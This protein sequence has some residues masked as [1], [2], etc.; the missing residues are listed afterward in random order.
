MNSLKMLLLTG[1][2]LLLVLPASLARTRNSSNPDYDVVRDFSLASNPNGTWSYGWA[3]STKSPFNLYTWSANNCDAGM[4]Y[5]GYYLGTPC[6]AL[7]TVGHN[8]TDQTLCYTTW[9]LPPNYLG[10][11]D[12]WIMQGDKY[13]DQL[14][15]VRWTAPSS[16]TFL[17]QGAV[18]GLDYGGT[19]LHVVVNSSMILFYTQVTYHTPVYFRHSLRLNAGDTV[20]FAVGW[21]ANQTI[22]GDATGI[23]FNL[24]LEDAK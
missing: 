6:S 10:M 22:Y 5:W 3:F 2:L 1:A 16:G 15:I 9:C 12:G 19:D 8:D 23:Q 11:H 14:S 21:G 18:V 4:S 7:P 20:D 17:L 24:T 13:V